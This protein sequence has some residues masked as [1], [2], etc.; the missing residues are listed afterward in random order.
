[1]SDGNV[2]PRRGGIVPEK[3][4]HQHREPRDRLHSAIDSCPCRKHIDRVAAQDR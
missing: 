4:D 3:I 2:V 1:M